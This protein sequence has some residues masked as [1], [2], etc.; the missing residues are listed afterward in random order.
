VSVKV[1][2]VAT[3][4]KRVA[5]FMLGALLLGEVSLRLVAKR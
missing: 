5:I 1:V 3:P 4:P 2:N